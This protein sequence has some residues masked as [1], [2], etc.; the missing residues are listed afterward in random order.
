MSGLDAAALIGH[1]RREAGLTQAQ[2]AARAGTSQ[3]AVARY[4]SGE[5][6]PAVSTL[7]RLLKA[8]GQQVAVSLRPV[9]SSDLSSPQ[10]QALRRHRGDVFRILRSIGARDVRIFGSVARGDATALS[11]IDLLIEFDIQKGIFMLGQASDD[12]TALLAYHVDLAPTIMLK[13][14]ILESALKDAIPL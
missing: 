9:S 5:T 2:L 13:P 1:A 12:L 8:C 14:H 4:E 3:P 11:D 6:S 7:N 10:A